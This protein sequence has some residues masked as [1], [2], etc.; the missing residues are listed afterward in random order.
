MP[1]ITKPSPAGWKRRRL[2][3]SR[4][5]L[6]LA[7][8]DCATISAARVRAFRPATPDWRGSGGEQAE[9]SGGKSY[10]GDRDGGSQEARGVA[11]E[12]KMPPQ[13][14]AV[15]DLLVGEEPQPKGAPEDDADRQKPPRRKGL[16]NERAAPVELVP[17]R[18]ENEEKQQQEHSLLPLQAVEQLRHAAQEE[19]QNSD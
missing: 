19:Q 8:G 5:R 2:S 17:R 6:A 15:A 11:V 10:H 18:Q 1:N 9:A 4:A 14:V 13:L 16:G 7:S 3:P 12:R